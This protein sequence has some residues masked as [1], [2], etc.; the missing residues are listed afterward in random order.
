[1]SIQFFKDQRVDVF[2]PL[3]TVKATSSAKVNGQSENKFV[4]S[5]IFLKDSIIRLTACVIAGFEQ[6]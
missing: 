6:S 1:M 3:T 2:Y 5:K 4:F